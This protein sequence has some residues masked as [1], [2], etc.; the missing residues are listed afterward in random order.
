M[1]LTALDNQSVTMPTT[2]L[3]GRDNEISRLLAM[4]ERPEVRLVTLLGPGGVGKTRIAL[5]L[6][7]SVK[8]AAEVEPCLVL[9]S[10]ARSAE[11]AMAA[12]ARSLGVP[13]AGRPIAERVIADA[14]GQRPMLLI[15]DNVEQLATHLDALPGWL[16]SCS[17]LKILTT[18]RVPLRYSA[19]RVVPIDPLATAT[20]D[21]Q[22]APASVLFIDRAQAM[23]PD[24]DL[25][26]VGVK[27]INEICQRLDGLPLAIELAAARTRFLP[28]AS[29]LQRL[30]SR[31]QV[32]DGGPRDAPKRHR[33]LRATIAWSYDLLSDD[34][35]RL[36]QR[37]AVFT[38]GGPL[39]AVGAVCNAS[40]DLEGDAETVLEALVDHSLVRLSVSAT[41]QPR[42]R[43]LH[44]I[45]EFALE[46]LALGDTEAEVRMAHARWFADCVL[47]EPVT[48]WRTATSE[49]R[50]W[51][52]SFLPDADNLT[53]A[54][55]T[56]FSHQRHD[57][58][59]G[60][61]AM[62][63][64]FWV[65]TGQISEAEFWMRRLEEH[66]CEATIQHR[67]AFQRMRAIMHLHLKE[68]STAEE[69]VSRAIM[70]TE[71][72]GDARMA[73]NN[74]HL[75]GQIF[76]EQGRAEEAEATTRLA[77][78][79][80][81]SSGDPLGGALYAAQL[82]EGLMQRGDLDQAETL[83]MEAEPVIQA[84]RPGA[85]PLVQGSLGVLHILRGNFDT[86]S[87]YLQQSLDYHGAPPYQ[88][89]LLLACRL[90]TAGYLA[91]KRG[92]HRRS[93]QL[94]GSGVALLERHG[95]LADRIW[96]ADSAEI[97]A[98]ARSALS[99]EEFAEAMA[100]G[101]AMIPTIDGAIALAR[102][103]FAIRTGGEQTPS[104]SLGKNARLEEPLTPR[105]LDVLR[106]L[107]AGRSNPAI[108]EDL[109]I[110]LR[111]VTTHLSRLYGKLGVSSRTEAVAEAMRLGIVQPTTH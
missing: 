31:L 72:A 50:Q 109:F 75:L 94:L 62:L 7:Q 82:A 36:F 77:M 52:M 53:V 76:W 83:L 22:L 40:G 12:I 63:L 20:A 88:S 34:E 37:L 3:V 57:L 49:L 28:P 18:S 35:Q 55:H 26:P 111:T 79:A 48:T 87:A 99:P 61:A 108:A 67:G 92:L 6:M 54:L 47:N 51:V 1:A 110:S 66:E 33:T 104:V 107:A 19:E 106:L 90:E 78:N 15:L 98:A 27:A 74:R 56:L 41:G 44:T 17:R 73:A 65:E 29:L 24:L 64:T 8:I 85:V 68:L 38:N 32:L 96:I 59:V 30:P 5:Q 25:S 93:L 95:G 103:V 23:R 101:G 70:L 80:M 69:A 13:F 91:M 60:M 45:R 102:E 21:G 16:A 11:D 42:F 14:I 81:I 89:P 10:T 97:T 2:L 39:E 86:A 105:E 43:I 58:A 71:Q 46:Q 4:L 9:L 84:H 100:E